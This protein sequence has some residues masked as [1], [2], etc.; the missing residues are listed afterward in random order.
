MAKRYGTYGGIVLQ[1]Q[2]CRVSEIKN[3]VTKTLAG[4]RLQD[5]IFISVKRTECFKWICIT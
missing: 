1:E 2:P 5:A 4:T 3:E